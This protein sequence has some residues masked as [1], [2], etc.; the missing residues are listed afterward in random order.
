MRIDFLSLRVLTAPALPRLDSGPVSSTGVTFFRRNDGL[1]AE[2]DPRA[3]VVKPA[4][5]VY[6]VPGNAITGL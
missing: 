3:A 2:D 6:A 1:G 4:V 5:L